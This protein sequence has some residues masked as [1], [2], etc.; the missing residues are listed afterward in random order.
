MTRGDYPDYRYVNEV[1]LIGKGARTCRYLTVSGGGWSCEKHG[2]MRDYLDRRARE[3]KMT[4]RAD[5][6]SG[7]DSR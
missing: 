2:Q 5:N 1:C 7:K 4:A 6:C 3:G